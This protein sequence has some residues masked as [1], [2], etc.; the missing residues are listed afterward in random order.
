MAAVES[1]M[2]ALPAVGVVRQFVMQTGR[3]HSRLLHQRLE[4]EVCPFPHS[5]F[6]KNGDLIIE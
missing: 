2:G 5:D 1:P 3:G 4:Y 6:G